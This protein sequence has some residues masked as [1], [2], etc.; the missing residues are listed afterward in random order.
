MKRG[1]DAECQ[2]SPLA[3]CYQM[4]GSDKFSAIGW[5]D[6]ILYQNIGTTVYALQCTDYLRLDAGNVKFSNHAAVVAA[7]VVTGG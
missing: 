6:R 4:P 2:G 7:F 3:R 1:R 5:T